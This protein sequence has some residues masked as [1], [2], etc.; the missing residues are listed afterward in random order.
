MD[1]STDVAGLAI[2]TGMGE[3]CP[4]REQNVAFR[5]GAAVAALLGQCAG[6]A[7]TPYLPPLPHLRPELTRKKRAFPDNVS[8]DG[9]FRLD[10][11]DEVRQPSRLVLRKGETR[12]REIR[13]S[14]M[15]V[16]EGVDDKIDDVCNLMKDGWHD[17]LCVNEIKRKGSSEEYSVSN[18]YPPRL[19]DLALTRVNEDAGMLALSYQKDYLK[20]ETV[21]NV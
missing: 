9:S 1:E 20:M 5:V 17:I 11:C 18:T 7:R 13:F 19:N 16:F 2:L 10:C 4:R 15:N 12:A 8:V 21:T 6:P 3:V 14:D